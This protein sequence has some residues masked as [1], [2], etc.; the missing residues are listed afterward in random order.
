MDHH[1]AAQDSLAF[2]VQLEGEGTKVDFEDGQV[3]RRSLEATFY[4]NPMGFA[5][6]FVVG[7]TLAAK[8]GLDPLEVEQ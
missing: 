1:F 5:F 8:N 4:S 6:A 3:V 2:G 7:P